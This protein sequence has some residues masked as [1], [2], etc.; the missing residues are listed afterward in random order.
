MLRGLVF[1]AV[2]R[3]VKKKVV[4]L[5]TESLHVFVKKNQE[6]EK[7]MLWSPVPKI[8]RTKCKAGICAM[9]SVDGTWFFSMV[10]FKHNHDLSPSKTRFF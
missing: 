9:L 6:K 5:I 4:V 8:I 1:A 7:V 10:V 2:K 3:G